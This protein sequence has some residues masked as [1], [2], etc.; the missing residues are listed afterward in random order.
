VPT[1]S[2]VT[3]FARSGGTGAQMCSATTG[4]SARVTVPSSGQANPQLNR[5]LCGVSTV[6]ASILGMSLTWW[7]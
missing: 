3:S 1:G 6:T 4:R 5:T 7:V 2:A